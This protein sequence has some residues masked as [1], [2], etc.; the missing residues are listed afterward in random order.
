MPDLSSNVLARLRS[1][2]PVMATALACWQ[3]LGLQ[4]YWQRLVLEW[5]RQTIVVVGDAGWGVRSLSSVSVERLA[6]VRWRGR[7]VGV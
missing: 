4:F 2:L 6:R 5:R 1:C 3:Q 7:S